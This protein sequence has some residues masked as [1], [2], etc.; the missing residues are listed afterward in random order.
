MVQFWAKTPQNSDMPISW[1]T[2]HTVYHHCIDV[3]L[4]AQELIETKYS[5]LKGFLCAPYSDIWMGQQVICCVAALHDI[6]KITPTFQWKVPELTDELIKEGF[7]N[8]SFSGGHAAHGQDTADFLAAYLESIWAE[9]PFPVIESFAQIA[10]AHHGKYF[11]PDPL[12]RIQDVW[13]DSRV[14]HT[15]R[16]CDLWLG[17]EQ[18]FP[19]PDLLDEITPQWTMLFTG[20]VCVSDWL[21]SSLPFPVHSHDASS[22]IEMRKV[23]I[24]M[25]LKKTGF[26]S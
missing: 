12:D 3:G 7:C 5:T 6:G 16:I 9:I 21:G 17:P 2:I 8:S 25:T 10:G 19:E 22:Y 23:Q 26:L 20:L 15:R 1:N 13:E 24:R 11:S 4:T 14:D 18:D